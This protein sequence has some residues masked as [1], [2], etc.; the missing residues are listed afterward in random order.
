MLSNTDSISMQM[1][2]ISWCRARRLEE[3]ADSLIQ[4]MLESGWLNK[5]KILEDINGRSFK[6]S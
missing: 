6:Q 3:N 4:F 1:M 5:Q 2:F